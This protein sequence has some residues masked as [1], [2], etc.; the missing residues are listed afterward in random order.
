MSCFQVQLE[1][2]SVGKSA[3]LQLDN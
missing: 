3:S 2:I 1:S